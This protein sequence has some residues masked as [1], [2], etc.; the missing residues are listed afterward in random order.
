MMG[1]QDAGKRSSSRTRSLGISEA[2]KRSSSR[3]SK[4]EALARMEADPDIVAE[5]RDAN[6]HGD[7]LKGLKLPEGHPE[8]KE[9]GKV[10]RCPFAKLNVVRTAHTANAETRQIV[11][12][13][14]G[15][16]VLRRFTNRFYEKAFQDPELDQFILDHDDPHGERFA[17][18]I[19]EKMGDGSPWTAERATRKVKTF[20]AYGQRFQTAHDRS[21]AHFAAWHSPKRDPSDWGEHFKLDTCRVW[22]RLHF[23]A[24]R[25]EGVLDHPAFA[26]YY[27]KLIGHFVSVYEGTAPPFARESMRWSADPNNIKRYLANG[28]RMP[29]IMGLSTRAALAALPSEERDYTGSK[30]GTH[31]PYA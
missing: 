22:M 10:S 3:T 24:A 26:D 11:R 16:P 18:W 23:W 6:A 1:M 15:L 2:R 19:A 25:E 13:L 17:C 7:K 4:L 8:I 30:K 9:G 21:S 20:V 27:C 29:E 14:G 31:W 5:M 28:R 12:D